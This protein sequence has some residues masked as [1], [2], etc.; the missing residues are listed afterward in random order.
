MTAQLYLQEAV[1]QLAR[2]LEKNMKWNS[3]EKQPQKVEF[4]KEADDPAQN[5][6]HNFWI[7]LLQSCF[8]KSGGSFEILV[9]S[10][11]NPNPESG[12]DFS[13]L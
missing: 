10:Q 13:A 2:G 3:S 11:K 5:G 7:N 1:M 4:G 9:L 12:S 6:R 8:S